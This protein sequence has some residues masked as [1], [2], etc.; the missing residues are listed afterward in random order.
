MD[1]DENIKKLL[2]KTK[3]TVHEDPFTIVSIRWAEEDKAREL[4]RR[5]TPFSSLTFDPAE[6]SLVAKAGDWEGLKDEFEGYEE[7]GPYRLITFD[8]VLDLAIVGFMAV[9]SARLADAGVSIFALS[10]YLKDHIL[11][12]ENDLERAVTELR[13]LIEEC[14]VRHFPCDE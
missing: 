12:K 1:I 9:V 11:V 8:I 10:T 4:S 2:A 13:E 14:R 3:I 5:I 7:E 6:I